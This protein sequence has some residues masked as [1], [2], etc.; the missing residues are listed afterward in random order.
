MIEFEDAIDTVLQRCV[1]AAPRPTAERRVPPHTGSIL[2]LPEMAGTCPD[3]S[4]AAARDL[5]ELY[6]A[7]IPV[8]W[9]HHSRA[10]LK[11]L[12]RKTDTHTETNCHPD[13]RSCN[14]QNANHALNSYDNE[15]LV[16]LEELHNTGLAVVWPADAPLK[17][18]RLRR[19]TEVSFCHDSKQS[20]ASGM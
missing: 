9:P 15:A 11:R 14:P 3:G 4:A 20:S 8:T 13:P 19:K 12:R 10:P 6:E 18:R 17:L 7:G 5:I 1:L 2:R 16:D